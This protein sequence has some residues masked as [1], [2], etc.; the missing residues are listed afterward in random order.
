M[1]RMHLKPRGSVYLLYQET[2]GKL[3]EKW[4]YGSR[5]AISR[6][7]SALKAARGHRG[8]AIKRK[9]ELIIIPNKRVSQISLATN[10]GYGYKRIPSNSISFY[11]GMG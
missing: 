8:A 5:A 1:L 2:Y 11:N 4:K 6:G 9:C 7:V 3:F 10:R